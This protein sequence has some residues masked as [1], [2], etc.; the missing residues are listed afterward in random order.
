MNNITAIVLTFNESMHIQRC[1][2]SIRQITEKIIVVDSGS[3]DGTLKIL[4][5]NNVQTLS[6]TWPGNHSDQFNWAL[7]QLPVDTQWVFRVDADEIISAELAGEL[8]AY[9]SLDGAKNVN[10]IECNRRMKFQGHFIRFGGVGANKVLRLF[11]YGFGKSE[12]RWMDEHITI[13]GEIH[14]LKGFIYDDN[15]NSL[16]WWIDKHNG[17]SS[18]EAIDILI[19]KHNSG[20]RNL[21]DAF[22]S[23]RSIKIKRLLKESIYL[24]LSPSHRSFLYFIYRYFV[25]LGFLDGKKGFRFHF[26]QAYWYR[27]LVDLKVLEVEEYMQHKGIGLKDAIEDK[28][29]YRL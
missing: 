5:K 29:G 17:Y 26:L 23:S 24:K 18:K 15:L 10:G 7:K 19:Q 13:D 1:L 8:Q 9:L 28:L 3:T 2:D 16:R 6:R 14:A 12:S 21:N 4:E 22:D 20:L 27:Y 25:C 11:K